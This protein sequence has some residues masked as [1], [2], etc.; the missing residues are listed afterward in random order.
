VD[1]LLQRAEPHGHL[2]PT[3][4]VGQPLVAEQAR[5]RRDEVQQENLERR[6]LPHHRFDEGERVG[7]VLPTRD[8]REL[9]HLGRG[10]RGA[11]AGTRF[12]RAE[13][14]PVG[15]E[16]LG[17]ELLAKGREQLGALLGRQRRGALE[18]L[19]GGGPRGGTI[20]AIAWAVALPDVTCQSGQTREGELS[21]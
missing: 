20:C 6:P 2:R 21:T 9:E 14:L 13:V 16:Q 10:R 15:D 12:G 4:L 17:H 5:G 8:A 18:Q 11:A 3:C 1:H 19:N 7:Q